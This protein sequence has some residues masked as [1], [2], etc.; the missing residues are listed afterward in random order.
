MARTSPSVYTPVSLHAFGTF[1]C[2]IWM[3]T[4][5]IGLAPSNTPCRMATEN[6]PPSRLF[7]RLREFLLRPFS[8]S[9]S[10]TRWPS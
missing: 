1:V 4:S 9:S 3:R 8:T 7:S 10:M 5:R 6:I 2:G